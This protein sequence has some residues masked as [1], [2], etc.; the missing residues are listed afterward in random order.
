MNAMTYPDITAYP[1]ATLNDKDFE[2]LL[3]VYLD[4]AFFPN[5]DEL[6]FMQEGHRVELIDSK[7]ENESL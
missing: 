6:D 5:L 7:K 4:A 1:F 3:S 2:N